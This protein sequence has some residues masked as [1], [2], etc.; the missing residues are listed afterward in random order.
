[1]RAC[2]PISSGSG[3][4]SGGDDDEVR[5]GSLIEHSSPLGAAASEHAP[6]F[7]RD[8]DEEIGGGGVRKASGASGGRPV[9]VTDARTPLL[10]GNGQ[11]SSGN[12]DGCCCVIM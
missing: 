6:A 1:M 3:S 12:A 2:A 10:N 7:M 9:T 4:G 11:Q 5:V 8:D